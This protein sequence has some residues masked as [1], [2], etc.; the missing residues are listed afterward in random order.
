PAG[1]N[2]QVLSTQV[3]DELA[4]PIRWGGFWIGLGGQRKPRRGSH[5]NDGAVRQLAV[6]SSNWSMFWPGYLQLAPFTIGCGHQGIH[7]AL[8][9][10]GH[11]NGGQMSIRISSA[12]PF[13]QGASN[14]DGAQRALIRIGHK[15]N[16]QRSSHGAGMSG[17]TK[18]TTNQMKIIEVT[19]II[20]WGSV[21]VREPSWTERLPKR[22]TTQKYESLA[23]ETVIA[24]AAMAMTAS[25]ICRSD[26]KPSVPRSGATIPAVVT[27]APVE[28]PWAVLRT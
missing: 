15:Q 7:G 3:I 10:V 13:G 20:P 5:L 25:A 28:D 9:A 23:W 26:S 17:H 2:D 11:R 22:V 19:P 18:S 8:S 1:P 12:N 24:P 14:F 4:H 27:M 6:Y 16:I 21:W